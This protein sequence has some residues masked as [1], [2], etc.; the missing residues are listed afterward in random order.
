MTASYRLHILTAAGVLKHI[1][2]VNP[3]SSDPTKGGFLELAYINQVNAVGDCAF[4]LD[5]AHVALP[6]LTDRAQVEV[7]RSDP[8][9]SIAWYRDWSGMFLDEERWMS[10]G[11]SLFKAACKGDQ[12]LL[13]DRI[14]AYDADTN[15]KTSFVG[16][17]GETV[18]K[19]IVYSNFTPG[20]ATV[21]NGRDVNGETTNTV[22]INASTGA[23][24]SVDWKCA[25][26]N[27]L[28]TLQK[29]SAIAGGDFDVI[30][31]APT[32]WNFIWYTGQRGTDRTA[33]VVFSLDHGNMAE[34]HYSKARSGRI[35]SVIVGGTGVASERLIAA[36]TGNGYAA[37]NNIEAF[38]N[39]SSQTPTASGLNALGDQYLFEHRDQEQFGFKVLQTPA[40]L[41]GRDYFLGDKVTAKFLT[42]TTTPKITS[43]SVSVKSG[44]DQV[45]IGLSYV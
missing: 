43:V 13:N 39:G 33:S 20:I 21:A 36:R 14:D 41:Y 10:D 31:I 30:K 25:R 18:M 4:T 1:L 29:L 15:L 24:N 40:C 32:I 8:D 17:P 35:T 42:I 3:S 38:Y 23:G 37:G 5:G 2:A 22:N 27:V 11:L 12:W 7:W 16:V 44:Q 34:P 45:D 26:D 9:N 28:E 6:D 19:Y